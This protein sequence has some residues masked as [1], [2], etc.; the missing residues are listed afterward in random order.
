[1][2]IDTKPNLNFEKFEQFTGDTLNLSGTTRVFGNIEYA[3]SAPLNLNNRS[4][5]D[6]GFIISGTSTPFN[7]DTDATIPNTFAYKSNNT[8]KG[9]G[10]V[11]LTN[12]SSLVSGV[13]TNFLND[14]NPTGLSFWFTFWVKDTANNWYRVDLGTITNNTSATIF[15]VHSR[16][17]IRQGSLATRQANASV[18]NMPTVPSVFTGITGTYDYFIGFKNWSDGNFS[19]VLGNSSYADNYSCA[20]G[21]SS[22]AAGFASNVIGFASFASGQY[23][24]AFGDTARA[25]NSWSY[26]IGRRVQSSG[27]HSLAMGVSTQATNDTSVSIG[28]GHDVSGTGSDRYLLSSGIAAFNLSENT[29]TQT[30]GHGARARASGIFAGQNA[31]VPANSDRSVVIGGLNIKATSATTDT[32]FMPRV[33]IGL[34][35]GGSLTTDNA[36]NNIL[37]RNATTGELQIRTA[38]SLTGA[39]VITASNGIRRVGNDIRLGGNITGATTIGLGNVNL[40]ITATTGTLRYGSNYSANY[41]A[42]SIPDVGY[43]TGLTSQRLLISSFNSYS[44]S[45]LTNINSRLLRTTFNSYT[46]STINITSGSNGLTKVGNDIRLGGNITGVTTIG[47][48]ANNLTFSATTG[49]LR[50][51]GDYSANYDARSIPDVDFV[52]GLTKNYLTM[53]V[54]SNA[55]INTGQKGTYTISYDGILTGWRLVADTL[56]DLTLDVWRANNSIPTNSNSIFSGNNPTLINQIL[57]SASDLNITV[58]NGDVFILEVE[59]N[60]ASKYIRIEFEITPTI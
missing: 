49:T 5:V 34:G 54:S 2:P 21:G 46:A 40:T 42:R 8:F 60:T 58:S 16:S 59:D 32:V 11:I 15:R 29:A 44:A 43:V 14:T 22:A 37:V 56:T 28:R 35:T 7:L 6:R 10:R 1:M 33:R 19:I 3:G 27:Q 25:T 23:S 9:P 13:S 53:G 12:G 36:N 48:G 38:A 31:D 41:D 24:Y 51:S 47:L 30:S 55:T 52:T 45:T 39:S 18:P 50:Y 26:A 4:L 57:N 20:F 17:L